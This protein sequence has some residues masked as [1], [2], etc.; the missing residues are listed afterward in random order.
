VS[1]PH[2]P[3]NRFEDSIVKDAFSHYELGFTIIDK[4]HLEIYTALCDLRDKAM[5][6]AK[7]EDLD[8]IIDFIEKKTVTHVATENRLMKEHNYEFKESHNH[9]NLQ[10]VYDVR[11]LH[12]NHTPEYVI[13]TFN[14]ILN[15]IDYR[16]RI[17][18]ESFKRHNGRNGNSG[19][20]P[21]L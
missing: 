8:R 7:S 5:A 21:L 16:D 1:A 11:S 12:L 20:A 19:P 6:G 15:H 3:F 13:F 14:E 4:Q 10:H 9:D 17:M 2:I 18:V